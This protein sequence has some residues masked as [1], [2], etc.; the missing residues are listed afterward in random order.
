[1][2]RYT[3]LVK[4]MARHRAA[5]IVI[6]ARYAGISAALCKRPLSPALAVLMHLTLRRA[7]HCH[8]RLQ[9]PF[10]LPSLTQRSPEFA[11][12]Q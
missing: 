2:R 11:H 4:R 8:M 1:M 7:P 10:P 12:G 6:C 5:V 3:L 9:N